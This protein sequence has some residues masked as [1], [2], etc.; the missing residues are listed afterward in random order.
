MT[1]TDGAEDGHQVMAIPHINILLHRSL[2]TQTLKYLY[3][4]L[5]Y[6]Y[7]D[8]ILLKVEINAINH[9]KKNIIWNNCKR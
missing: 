8:E 7:L 2:F 6:H 9:K 3:D 5:F 4:I 1:L